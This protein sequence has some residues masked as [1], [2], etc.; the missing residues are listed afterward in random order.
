MANEHGDDSDEC[1]N[2]C[3]DDENNTAGAFEVLERLPQ[4]NRLT[5][6]FVVHFLKQ[7]SLHEEVN[8]MSV[9]N[10]AMV[11][12]PNYLRCPSEDPQVILNNTKYE[13]AWLR[14]LMAGI[15]LDV[16]PKIE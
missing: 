15:D 7:V 11:F 2:T 5:A 16:P 6:L 3:K 12:A 14:S 13:Q 9:A 4:V 8:K 10:L 1:I